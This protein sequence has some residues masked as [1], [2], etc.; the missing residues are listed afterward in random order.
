[1]LDAFREIVLADTEFKALP[2][3]GQS[4]FVWPLTSCAADAVLRCG[5]T[6]LAHGRHMQPG[7]M[8][9]SSLTMHQQN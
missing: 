7:R 5:K 3:S 2:V 8:F 4:P 1:M 9:S 6:N